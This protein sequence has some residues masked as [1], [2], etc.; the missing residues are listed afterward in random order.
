MY[1]ISIANQ[2]GGSGKTTTAVN[3]AACLSMKGYRSLLIDLDPQAQAS[4]C[5]RAE[6]SNSNKN[7]FDALIEARITRI[8]IKEVGLAISRK[9]TLLPS[10]AIS[11]DEE[12]A[13]STQSNCMTRLS[14]QLT[15][16]KDDFDFAIIDCP[17]TLG[18]LTQNALMASNAVLLTVETS[19]LALHGVGRLLELVQAIRR[20]KAL[21]VFAVATMYDGRTAFAREVLKDMQ[22]YFE[23]ALLSTVIRHNVRLKE[24]ACHGM[25][26]FTYDRSSYGAQDYTAMT[27][28]LLGKIVQGIQEMKNLISMNNARTQKVRII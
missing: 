23:E 25:P 22:G 9:L 26:I 18:V 14:Q 6:D 20:E 27:D 5:L 2:K 10:A 19:F 16:V 24:A 7:I 12:V 17:P 8:P 13:L 3:L 15:A 21:R 11:P 28:E 1:T 4:T